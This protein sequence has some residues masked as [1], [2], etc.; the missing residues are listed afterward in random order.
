MKKLSTV[1][2]A[3]TLAAVFSVTGVAQSSAAPIFVPKTITTQSDL[4]Q[5]RDGYR[6][7]HGRYN[8]YRGYRNFR[9]NNGIPA[10]AFIAGA[11]IGGAIANSGYYGGGYYGSSYYGNGYYP[12]RYYAR[13]YQERVY[14]PR[15]NAYRQGYVDGYRAGYNDG[16]YGGGISCTERLQTAGKC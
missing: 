9:Y 12:D 4:I 6:W 2:T 15:R 1:F 7:R 3:A 13:P 8:G 10:G 14:Y 5:V 16:A 11:L